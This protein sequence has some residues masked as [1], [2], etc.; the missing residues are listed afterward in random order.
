MT[1]ATWIATVVLGVGSVTVFVLFL[2]DLR[3]VVPPRAIGR[4]DA[5]E[6]R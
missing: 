4:S 6:G 3:L 1:L 5:S 2:R